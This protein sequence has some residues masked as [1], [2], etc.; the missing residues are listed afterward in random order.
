MVM[1]L[2]MFALLFALTNLCITIWYIWF[3]KPKSK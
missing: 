3:R 2:S 1:S